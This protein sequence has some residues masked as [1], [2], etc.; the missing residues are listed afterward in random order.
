MKR[1]VSY[2]VALS[3]AHDALDREG[4]RRLK[5]IAAEEELKGKI[6]ENKKLECE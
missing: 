6:S 2:S 3:A 5:T 1:S 4:T